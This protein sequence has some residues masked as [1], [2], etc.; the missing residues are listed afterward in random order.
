VTLKEEYGYKYNEIAEIIGKTPH[1]V[2]AKVGL[3]KRLD[4][5]VRISY[6]DDKEATHGSLKEAGCITGDGND[7]RKC[8][9]NTFSSGGLRA[10]GEANDVDMAMACRSRQLYIMNVNV[11][12]DIARLPREAQPAAY[13]VI[14]AQ[15]MD[16]DMAI[17]YLRTVKNGKTDAALAARDGA[18]VLTDNIR[19][20]RAQD[21]RKQ[22]GKVEK[23]LECLVA[24]LRSGNNGVN[25]E[26]FAEIELLIDRLSALCERLKAKTAVGREKAVA[27]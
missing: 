1:Y 12:E 22:I 8:I 27:G 9:Q 21:I 11:L 25:P 10:T 24:S 6:L 7:R 15:Q 5:R 17:E 23:D 4:P 14:M 3:I 16:K 13:R 19:S 26:I 18:I 2:A 20:R